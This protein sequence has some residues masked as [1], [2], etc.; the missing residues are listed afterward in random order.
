MSAFL[1][2]EKT[3]RAL[4]VDEPK[5]R[6]VEYNTRAVKA[7]SYSAW[8]TA[9]PET[10]QLLHEWSSAWASAAMRTDKGKP[11]G[12]IPPSIPDP[13]PNQ[14]LDLSIPPPRSLSLRRLAP[15]VHRER[16]TSVSWSA[17]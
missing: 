5:S 7:M 17:A 16:C 9:R 4:A 11:R 14:L 15:P 12:I 1:V 6:D 2:S 10:V 8:L 13:R 3:L